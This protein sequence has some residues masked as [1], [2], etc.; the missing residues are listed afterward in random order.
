[1]DVAGGYVFLLAAESLGLAPVRECAAMGD[2]LAR[3]C[4]R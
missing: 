3:V 2:W 4:W 1:M